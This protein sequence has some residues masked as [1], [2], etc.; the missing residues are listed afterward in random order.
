MWSVLLPTVTHCNVYIN[1]N[2][3]LFTLTLLY[4]VRECHIKSRGLMAGNRAEKCSTN[5]NLIIKTEFR[6]TIHA[7]FTFV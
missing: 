2:P 1:F 4:N 7:L 6:I 5:F 3:Q